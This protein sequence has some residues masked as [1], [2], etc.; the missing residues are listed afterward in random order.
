MWVTIQTETGQQTVW[1]EIRTPEEQAVIDQAEA[2]VAATESGNELTLRQQA[3][4]ALPQ[5]RGYAQNHA[6]P[7]VRLL[8]RVAIGVIRLIIRKLDGTA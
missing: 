7:A 6:D 1:M 4:G 8:C 2:Q 3:E 5:L